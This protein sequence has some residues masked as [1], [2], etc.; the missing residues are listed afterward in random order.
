M[1]RAM[2]TPEQTTDRDNW[3]PAI[4]LAAARFASGLWAGLLSGAIIGGIG[5]RLAMFL[6]RLTS[7]PLLRGAPTD[8]G[9]TIGKFTG[10]TFFLVVITAITGLLGG[11]FYLVIRRWIPDRLRAIAMGALAAAVG[12]AIVIKPEGIDFTLLEPLPLAIALFVLLPALYGVATS[13]LTERFLQSAEERSKRR[14]LLILAALLPVLALGPL[15]I[16]VVILIFALWSA[17]WAANQYVPLS[18]MWR[19]APVTW[20]GRAA[21]IGLFLYAGAALIKDSVEIL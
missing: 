2:D 20:L 11:I 6:L 12:G 15:G 14:I 16:L 17:G 1:M 18:A 9:F 3:V 7:D 4:R 19:S 21:L 8:D 5:G 13:L 10:D